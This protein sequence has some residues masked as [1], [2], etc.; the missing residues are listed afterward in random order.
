MC[1]FF[2]LWLVEGKTAFLLEFLQGVG[3]KLAAKR[4][5]LV[6]NLW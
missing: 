6:V 3:Q 4:G 1:V 2:C 5:D